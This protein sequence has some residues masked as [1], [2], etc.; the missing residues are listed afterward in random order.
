MN[1]WRVPI[2]EK[3][4]ETLGPPDPVTFGSSSEQ[5]GLSISS[6]GKRFAYHTFEVTS[7][8]MK[9]KF[10]LATKTVGNPEFVTRGS[11]NFIQPDLSPDGRS[12]VFR[13]QRGQEDIYVIS[14]DGTGQQPWTNDRPN[15]RRPRWSPDG[16]KISFD[17]TRS[18]SYQ[19]WTINPDGSGSTQLTYSP[20]NVTAAMWS[21]DGSRI[22][23]YDRTETAYFIMEV[24]KGWDEREPMQLPP[25]G[26]GD[27]GV[28]SWSPDGQ[29]LAG[30]GVRGAPPGSHVYSFESR[31][32]EKLTNIGGVP[33]WLSDNRT[34]VYA[35]GGNIHAVDCVSKQVWEILSGPGLNWVVPSP[36]DE[37]L[38]YTFTSPP[39]SDTFLIELP[40]DPQ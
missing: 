11:G 32:Y 8:I 37:T 7:N 39:E 6:D 24:D 36:N 14:L 5:W 29:W 17:S 2:D 20:D 40:D 35:A 9:V 34:L 3:T 16:T 26:D 28:V 18:G 27:F 19:I 1:L 23:Y 33:R 30:N 21:H 12:L 15:D 10:D 4:G 22:A 38:Y 13:S 31:D 25:L